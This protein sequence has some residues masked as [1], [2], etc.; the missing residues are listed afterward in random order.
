MNDSLIF[1]YILISAAI[2]VYIGIT[3]AKLKAKSNLSAL[4]ER[5][6]LL[7]QNITNLKE[8]LGKTENERE[9][10]RK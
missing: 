8:N 3:I 9:S 2:G 5:Q 4:E 7:S 1:L 10:I 6:N